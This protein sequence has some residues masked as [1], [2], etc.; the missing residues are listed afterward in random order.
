MLPSF[1]VWELPIK[2][3]E[4]ISTGVS[5]SW[6]RVRIWLLS[7]ARPMLWAMPQIVSGAAVSRRILRKISRE[8]TESH[9]VV[10]EKM[11]I[12]LVL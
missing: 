9:S 7:P 3:V 6:A 8:A 12:K 5:R 1:I 2:T 4:N 10:A 11:R